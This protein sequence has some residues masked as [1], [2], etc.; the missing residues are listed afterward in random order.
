MSENKKLPYRTLGARLKYIRERRQES[1]D[2]VSGALE[3]D[4]NTLKQIEQ[5][6][7]KKKGGF[8]RTALTITKPIIC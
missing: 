1:I 4:I 8:V 6:A 5:G 2:A 3:I 7:Q